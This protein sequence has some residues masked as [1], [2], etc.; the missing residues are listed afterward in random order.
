MK[1]Q[2]CGLILYALP[3]VHFITYATAAFH[4]PAKLHLK[5]NKPLYATFIIIQVAYDSA[6]WQALN[7][8]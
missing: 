5:F 4:L 8:V 1:L 7:F 3:A 6:N 2:N